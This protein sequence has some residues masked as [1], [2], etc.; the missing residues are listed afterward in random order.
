MGGVKTNP[1]SRRSSRFPHSISSRAPAAR[2]PLWNTHHDQPESRRIAMAALLNQQLA[3]LLDL[4]LQT[5]QA[6]WNVKGAQFAAL[7]AFFDEATG[8]LHALADELAERAVMLG[9][10]AQG[11]RQALARGSRLPEFPTEALSGSDTLWPLS[12]AFSRVAQST[13]NAIDAA[14]NAGD[15]GTADVLTVASRALDALLWKTEAHLALE[16]VWLPAAGG[17]QSSDTRVRPRDA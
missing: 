1:T 17:I 8:G 6:H 7:H 12:A 15:A 9:G 13:R 16:P 4:A 3:D 2:P 11:T 5:K 10:V 14:A